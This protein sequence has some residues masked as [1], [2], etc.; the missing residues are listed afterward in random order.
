M[1]SDKQTEANRLNAQHSTGPRSDEGKA[2]S[3]RNALKTGID[4]E[5]L[6]LP[7][8][9]PAELEA[10]RAE[11]YALHQPVT[12]EER[13][14]V[15]A[16]VVAVWLMRRFRRMEAQLTQHEIDTTEKLDTANPL[17][18]IFSQASGKFLRL[19]TRMNA[20]ERSFHRNSDRLAI[21][22]SRRVPAEPVV[23]PQPDPPSPDPEPADPPSPLASRPPAPEMA[24][25]PKTPPVPESPAPGPRPPAPL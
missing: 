21:L 9:D 3:S 15:D 23:E 11:Y 17:G 4:S 14:T 1:T 8:E 6:I 18:H 24:S 25:S 19:Q 12:P 22:K 5:S 16:A 10:L 20:A 7:G 2:R 13:D